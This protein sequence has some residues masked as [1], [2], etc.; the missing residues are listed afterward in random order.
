MG[1]IKRKYT[2]GERRLIEI[3]RA[4]KGS[5][6]SSKNIAKAHYPPGK[7]PVNAVRSV[8]TTLNSI[9]SK[10]KRSRECFIIMKT[11][12]R[13]PFPIEFWIEERGTSRRENLE[14]S[15]ERHPR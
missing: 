9:I 12:R 3:L 11:E 8:V 6:M 14:S 7:S 1:S 10:N 15:S 5:P 2:N 13:G 4:N